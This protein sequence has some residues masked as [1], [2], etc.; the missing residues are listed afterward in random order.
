[1]AP[2]SYPFA[3][4]YE[5]RASEND[6]IAKIKQFKTNDPAMVNPNFMTS[7]GRRD[8][9]YWYYVY[10]YFEDKGETPLTWT[11]PA[12]NGNTELALVSVHTS[13]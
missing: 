11:P 5:M 8:S 2:G 7:E 10:Y 3:D 6:V 4:V 13:A 1:M 12:E 9:S